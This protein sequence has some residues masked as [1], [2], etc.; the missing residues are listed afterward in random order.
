MYGYGDDY[1]LA[2]ADSSLIGYA[3][4]S[5]VMRTL[6]P[7][8]GSTQDFKKL[9]TLPPDGGLNGAEIRLLTRIGVGWPHGAKQAGSV[10]AHLSHRVS[11]HHVE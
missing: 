10:T 5:D 1:S 8:T 6:R 11:C 2:A 9:Q 3:I 7:A 4:F